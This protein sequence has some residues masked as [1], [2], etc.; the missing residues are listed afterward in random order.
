MIIKLKESVS[1]IIK[2]VPDRNIDGKWIKILDPLKTLKN[3][4]FRVRAIVSENHSA[5][6]LVYKL[7]L[8]ES[9][10][11]DDDLF[12]EHDYQKIYLLHDAIH[13][14]KT[15]EIIY[16]ST[17]TSYFQSLD[18]MVLKIQFYSKVIKFLRNYFTIFL[19]KV[20]WLRL[21]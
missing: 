15:E 20:A 10:H 13:L 12:M 1:Y 18:T 16:L 17:N 7:L 5:S 14:L 21:N 2:S 4:G 9:G 19:K 3:Y 8:M 11:L 6:V